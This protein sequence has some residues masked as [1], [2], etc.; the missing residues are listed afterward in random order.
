VQR[1]EPEELP[2]AYEEWT[3]AETRRLQQGQQRPRQRKLLQFD[4]Y[5][6]LLH[7][8]DETIGYEN[9]VDSNQ[10]AD[11]YN[12]RR[13]SR[14]P[15]QQQQLDASVHVPGLRLLHT[16]HNGHP[17]GNLSSYLENSLLLGEDNSTAADDGREFFLARE[18]SCFDKENYEYVFCPF[19]TNQCGQVIDNH[20]DVGPYPELLMCYSEPL[21]KAN[22][23]T[24]KILSLLTIVVWA[25]FLFAVMMTPKGRSCMSFIPARLPWLK[26]IWNPTVADYLLANH[27]D[28]AY[29]MIG[30][31]VRF[32]R[33]EIEL[34]FERQQRREER[35]RLR[36]EARRG[37]DGNNA[38][39]GTNDV[40]DN[41]GG[42]ENNRAAAMIE[43]VSGIGL[44][45]RRQNNRGQR[46]T[47]LVLHTKIYQKPAPAVFVESFATGDETHTGR[48]ADH[49]DQHDHADHDDDEDDH[50]HECAICYT[51]FEDGDRV[52][53]LPCDHVFHVECLKM[54]LKRQNVC[55]FCRK[56][57]V[58][59]E[60][61]E[62]N[63]DDK[64][65]ENNG[66]DGSVAESGTALASEQTDS[67]AGSDNVPV[68]RDNA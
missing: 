51:A 63:E 49:A 31:H 45:A 35:R 27:R 16:N 6:S 66:N 41:V 36:A 38:A 55:P 3:N 67:V 52:G 47:S 20:H 26:D 56:D 15:P 34:D 7:K 44:G 62:T 37:R 10:Q 17:S 59:E 24:Y 32:L 58:A 43:L 57:H 53:S 19:A 64:D 21:Q 5:S 4:D 11:K 23:N 68:E 12:I 39:S 61:F 60:R 14:R 48:D 1:Y 8:Q 9:P 33:R 18:C 50:A 65:E 30:S 46:P 2:K 22:S 13:L 25:N 29:R 54:W 40:V 42:H 28:Q